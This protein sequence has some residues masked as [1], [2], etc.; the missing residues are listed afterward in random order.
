MASILI[1]D[2]DAHIRE[3]ARFALATAS[4]QSATLSANGAQGGSEIP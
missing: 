2:D 3:V 4:W 1:V